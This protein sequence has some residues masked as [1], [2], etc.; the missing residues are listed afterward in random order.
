M[1]SR[2]ETHLSKIYNVFIFTSGLN[3]LEANASSD[4]VVIRRALRAKRAAFMGHFKENSS[5][6]SAYSRRGFH[7]KMVASPEGGVSIDT[8]HHHE[9]G[10]AAEQSSKSGFFRGHNDNG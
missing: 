9:R 5:K 8:K 3:D 1:N 7:H 6:K 10:R 2:L 4:D